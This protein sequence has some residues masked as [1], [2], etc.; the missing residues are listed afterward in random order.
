MSELGVDVLHHQC[1]SF[2]FEAFF[3]IG[4]D[5]SVA[6]YNVIPKTLSV[7]SFLPSLFLFAG[8]AIMRAFWQTLQNGFLE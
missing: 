6:G 5:N 4:L 7:Q 8:G 1:H 3:N 2:T